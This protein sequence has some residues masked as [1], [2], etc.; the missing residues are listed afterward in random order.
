MPGNRYLLLGWADARGNAHYI[1]WQKAGILNR[2]VLPGRIFPIVKGD[3]NTIIKAAV[4]ANCPVL[5]IDSADVPSVVTSAMMDS[6]APLAPPSPA[7][8]RHVAPKRAKAKTH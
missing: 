5:L 2:N 7:Q 6:N 8:T 4:A 3:A 1:E